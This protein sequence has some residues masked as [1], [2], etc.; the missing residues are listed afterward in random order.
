MLPELFAHPFSFYSAKALIAFYDK[1]APFKLRL[2]SGEDPSAGEEMAR[3]WPMLRFPILKVGERTLVETSIIIEWL[4]QQPAGAGSLIP[5]DADAALDVRMRDRIFDNY[6][7]SP[8][9]TI[10]F[11]ATRPAGQHD[12]FGVAQARALLERAYAW[13]DSEMAERRWASGSTFSLADCA[14]APALLYADWVHPID[15]SR[16]HLLAYRSRLLARPS[17]ARVVEEARPFRSNFPLP[18]PDRD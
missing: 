9:A 8:M 6:V 13:L 1:G 4:D 2:L 3:L 17:V 10:T 5:A 15:P 18:V 16:T 7:M 12:D 11:D 14:A